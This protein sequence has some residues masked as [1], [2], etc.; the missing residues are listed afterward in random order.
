MQ[1][2]GNLNPGDHDDEGTIV[3]R[4]QAKLNG[5]GEQP[6]AK[7]QDHSGEFTADELSRMEFDEI[8]YVVPGYVAEGLTLFAGK[9]KI[10]KSWF[11]MHV[12][13]SVA[14]GDY[15]LGGIACEEGDVLYAALEDNKRRLRRR[16]DKLF[17]NIP[18]P[19]RLTFKCEMPRL[20]EGGIDCIRNWLKQAK[21][22]RLV[23][24]DT[25]AMVRMPNRKDQSNYEADYASM[26]DLRDL[27]G[28][29][30]VAI[31]IVHH[32]RKA[33]ADDPF[34]TISGTLGLTGAADT[35]MVLYRETNG[36]ILAARGRDIEE[37]SKAAQFD[38]KTCLWTIVG[39]ADA[40]RLSAERTAIIKAFEE[41]GS[42]PLGPA[43]VAQGTGM[44]AANV[45]NLLRK[46][47]KDGIINKAKGYGKYTLAKSDRGG[48]E[49]EE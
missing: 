32:L 3:R 40:I 29:F 27:A 16:M 9:P 21:Q 36:I 5:G 37:V 42:E 49:W 46:M 41:A 31:I 8:K 48:N 39:D 20:A 4:R 38:N 33:D 28:E 7:R 14:C 24:I 43:Q 26:K 17:G 15:T 18:W 10:G 2:P 12:A 19:K 1:Q 6:R 44:K 35:I 34:D 11:L 22:P 25:L 13:W 30:G 47:L 23:V 45:R